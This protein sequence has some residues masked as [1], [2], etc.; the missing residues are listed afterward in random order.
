MAFFKSWTPFIQAYKNYFTRHPFQEH[1]LLGALSGLVFFPVPGIQFMLLATLPR[2]IL[3]WDRAT[4]LVP[5]LTRVWVFFFAFF[6]VSLYWICHAFFVEF[7]LFWWAI[8]ISLLGVPAFLALTPT[9]LAP[10]FL[11]WSFRVASK[12]LR[13]LFLQF[14][15][16]DDYS[17]LRLL[18]VATWIGTYEFFLA[19]FFPWVAL[20]NTWAAVPLISQTSALGGVFTL[21]FL[22][23]FIIGMPYLWITRA[24]SKGRLIAMVVGG[25]LL[26]GIVG[27]GAYRLTRPVEQITFTV[28]LVQP[29]IPHRVEWN[30]NEQ[31]QDLNRLMALS[32]S[33]SQKV[34]VIIWP[35]AI[36]N[37]SLDVGSHLPYQLGA[38]LQGSASH[39]ITGAVRREDRRVWNSLYVVGEDGHVKGHYDKHHLVPF[40]EYIPYRTWLENVLGVKGLRKVTAGIR[41][42]SQGS[43]LKVFQIPGL[44]S[45]SPMICFEAIFPG[46][47][48]DLNSKPAWLVQLTEDSWFGGSVGPYQHLQIARMR[49]IEEG[50]PVVRVANTGISAVIDPY[51]RIIAQMPLG[52][53]GAL[54][55]AVPAPL[56]ERPLSCAFYRWMQWIDTQT[57]VSRVLG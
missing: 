31:L 46:Q 48:S 53:I 15:Q 3:L 20:G 39:L 1:C 19:D 54:D 7:D 14:G 12:P 29:G 37:F 24:H 11:G 17:A 52:H 27:Y 34:D 51:G 47:V 50:V 16:G 6:F 43:G 36:L 28:R 33:S 4:G 22:T 8:P 13:I 40:G 57:S 30:L 32:K 5:F 56:R 18:M 21:S 55:V 41:D 10:W 45:F 9:L 2:W 49:A 23:I 42:F 44:P 38:M 25:F 35:E 26:L